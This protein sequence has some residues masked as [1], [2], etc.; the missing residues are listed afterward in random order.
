MDDLDVELLR[1]ARSTEFSEVAL[2]N[3][4]GRSLLLSHADELRVMEG[5]RGSRRWLPPRD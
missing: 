2:R 4:Q 1:L 5:K 3:L